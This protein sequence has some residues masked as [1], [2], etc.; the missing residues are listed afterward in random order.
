MERFRNLQELYEW[1]AA[2]LDGVRGR[3]REAIAEAVLKAAQSVVT[4]QGV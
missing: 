1:K 3:M 4:H 2:D